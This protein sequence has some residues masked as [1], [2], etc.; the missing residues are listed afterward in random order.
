MIENWRMMG[1]KLT[2][3]CPLIFGHPNSTIPIKFE[4]K[5]IELIMVK[6]LQRRGE[7]INDLRNPVGHHACWSICYVTCSYRFQ[8]NTIN[9]LGQ[10]LDQNERPLLYNCYATRHAF[11]YRSN[12]LTRANCFRS[13]KCWREMAA[14]NGQPKILILFLCA[15]L[16]LSTAN[17]I[18]SL[19]TGFLTLITLSI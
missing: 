8:L 16:L 9:V 2:Q 10:D 19:A 13:V 6:F 5:M 4:T 14:A 17:A 11:W 12:L 1:S 7:I 15:I 3:V 18:R